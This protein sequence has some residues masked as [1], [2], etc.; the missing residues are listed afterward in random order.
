MN[1]H[2][3][4]V[5]SG[6]VMHVD[7]VDVEVEVEVE[8]VDDVLVEV[9]GDALVDV[10]VEVDED[11]VV[12]VDVIEL[13][14]VDVDVDVVEVISVFLQH[15]S[16]LYLQSFWNAVLTLHTFG[17]TFVH[18]SGSGGHVHGIVLV[19]VE[20]E[21]EVVVEVEEEVGT[22]VAHICGHAACTTGPKRSMVQ[23]SLV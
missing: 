5:G 16:H 17:L 18:R 7:D 23:Y 21:V 11:V 13:V 4:I 10:E 6:S 8:V 2:H 15:V 12:V 14:E 9:V 22:V 3:L 20:V 1:K 19:E